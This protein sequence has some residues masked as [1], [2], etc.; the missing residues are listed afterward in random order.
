MRTSQVSPCAVQVSM[1]HADRYSS[2]PTVPC[3]RLGVPLR[4]RADLHVLWAVHQREIARSKC[5]HQL[6]CT[7]QEGLKVARLSSWAPVFSAVE[8]DCDEEQL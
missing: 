5:C 3:G 7:W 2:A 1:A 4:L 8:C 6:L